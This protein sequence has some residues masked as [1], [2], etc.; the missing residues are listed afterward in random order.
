MRSDASSMLDRSVY[1][2]VL[3]ECLPSKEAHDA[4]INWATSLP[5]LKLRM[6]VTLLRS[7]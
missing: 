1:N 7:S 3:H 4:L 6:R 2:G 5:R